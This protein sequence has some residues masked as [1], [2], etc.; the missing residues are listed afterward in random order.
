MKIEF[1]TTAYQFSHGRA[2]RGEGYWGFEVAGI[3][4]WATGT[5]GQAKR[6]VSREIRE[7]FHAR[8][9]VTVKVCP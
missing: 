5:L 8:K 6:A 1:D 7:A 9:F 3:Q 2:P 4:Y